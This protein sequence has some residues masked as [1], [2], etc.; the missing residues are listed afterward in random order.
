MALRNNLLRLAN[1]LQVLALIH[2]V[3]V[4]EIEKQVDRLLDETE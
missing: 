1:K 4:E 2:P 3:G